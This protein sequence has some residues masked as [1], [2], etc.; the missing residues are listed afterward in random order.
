MNT[1]DD[2]LKYL[3]HLCIFGIKAGLSRT[4]ELVDKLG[5]PQNSYRT[6]HVAG[7]NG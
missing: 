7:T 4:L 6:V 3:E 5:N 1:F 2:A